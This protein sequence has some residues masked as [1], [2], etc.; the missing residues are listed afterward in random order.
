MLTAQ[1]TIQGAE[2]ENLRLNCQTVCR[3]SECSRSMSLC[4][5]GGGLDHRRNFLHLLVLA[6]VRLTNCLL[7]N[8]QRSPS[9]R[10]KHLPSGPHKQSGAMSVQPSV[11]LT[12]MPVLSTLSPS[13]QPQQPTQE[14]HSKVGEPIT[15]LS[16]PYM[17]LQLNHPPLQEHKHSPVEQRGGGRVLYISAG[18]LC[19]PCP[20]HNDRAHLW[21]TPPWIGQGRSRVVC[22]SRSKEYWACWQHHHP[23]LPI[24]LTFGLHG[25][26]SCNRLARTAAAKKKKK[27]TSRL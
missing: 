22:T 16:L 8:I 4:Q 26:Y 5:F 6:G 10:R 2:R 13:W 25:V 14:P 19:A 27:I 15:R 9:V 1:P 21:S 17:S 12:S 18:K 23:A 11:R 7:I 20:K 3:Q 24:T